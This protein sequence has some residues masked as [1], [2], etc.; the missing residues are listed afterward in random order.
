MNSTSRTP[1]FR[2]SPLLLAAAGLALAVGLL[3]LLIGFM[4]PSPDAW[5]WLLVN[6]VFFGGI[7]N[8]VLVWSAAFRVAQARWTCVINR[9]GHSALAFVPVLFLTLLGL[10]SGVSKWAPWVKHPIPAKAA[11]LN[12]PFM[13]W[14]DI[15]CLG[16]LWLLCFLMVRWSLKLDGRAEVTS[17]DQ[18]RLTAIGTAVVLTYTV[19][20]SI[21]AYDFVMSLSPEWVSTMFAPS[22]GSPISTP[23]WLS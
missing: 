20:G 12:V 18:Y 3:G 15:A 2:P 6:F 23:G 1:A 11:W 19:T 4:A 8:G 9:L 22:T 7:A 16:V 13:I 21:V 17:K 14:R 5:V 10:L